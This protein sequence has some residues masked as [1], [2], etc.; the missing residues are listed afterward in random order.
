MALG[1]GRGRAFLSNTDLGYSEE[2]EFNIE[3]NGYSDSSMMQESLE[4]E[5]I[6]DDLAQSKAMSRSR[7]RGGAQ[8]RRKH[9]IQSSRDD[10]SIAEGSMGFGFLRGQGGGQNDKVSRRTSLIDA[11]VSDSNPF[12]FLQK[13][14]DLA[15][16]SQPK[17]CSEEFD[18]EDQGF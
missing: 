7:S 2:I 11:E 15:P 12:G 17:R 16:P 10:S 9:A 1:Q 3:G 5:S 4:N 14:P 18:Q 13:K 8:N 6:I